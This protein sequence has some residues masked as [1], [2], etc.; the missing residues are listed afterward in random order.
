MYVI[1]MSEKVTGT[2]EY[3]DK[4]IVLLGHQSSVNPN[5]GLRFLLYIADLY[6]IFIDKKT[7]YKQFLVILK[8]EYEQK[9]NKI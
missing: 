6:E 9:V 7:M 1:N 5:V 3:E 4:L 8:L 2:R